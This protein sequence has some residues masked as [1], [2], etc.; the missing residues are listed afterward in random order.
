MVGYIYPV[1]DCTEIASY[2][3]AKYLA[4]KGHNV[5]VITRFDEILKIQIVNKEDCIRKE[6]TLCN[7]KLKIYRAKRLN[8]LGGRLLLKLIKA[9][10]I[11]LKTPPDVILG[12]TLVLICFK[13]L[14]LKYL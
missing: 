6:E 13:C 7:G 5:S 1:L 11:S 14:I 9:L 4:Q 12:F 3:I 8:I 10:K 2:N